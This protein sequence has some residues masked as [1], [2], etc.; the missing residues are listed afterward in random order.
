MPT[1]RLLIF[2]RVPKPGTVKTR[3]AVKLGDEAAAD[4]YNASLR[5]V[6]A[7]AGRERARVELWYV[8]SRLARSYFTGEF[9]LV[10]TAPQADGDLGERMADAFD[11][12]FRDGAE[13]VV[14]LGSDVPTLPES[15]LNAAFDALHEG[16]NVVGPCADGGYYLIGLQAAIWPQARVLFRDIEWSSSTVLARTLENAAASD[17]TLDVLP[18]WYDVDEVTDLDR[19]QLDATPDS[20]FG[21]WLESLS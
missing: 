4:F 14:I 19:A 11:R 18:G 9:S 16:R 1:D 20:H 6:I 12:S 15:H 8:D 17:I 13:R 5:D 2:C 21:R 7:L 3:L 10:T